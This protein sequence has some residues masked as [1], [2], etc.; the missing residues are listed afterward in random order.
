M[1]PGKATAQMPRDVARR[2]LKRSALNQVIVVVPRQGKPSRVFDLEKYRKMQELPKAVQP[3]S[4]RK[5]KKSG[6]DPLG[7]VD[8]RVLLPLTRDQMYD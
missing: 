4:K 7:A 1:T 5:G 6:P 8:G 2:I 3:W